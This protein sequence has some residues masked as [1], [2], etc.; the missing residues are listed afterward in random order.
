[1][2]RIKF[3][4]LKP[5]DIILTASK[6]K[7]GKS[8]RIF[9]QGIVSHAMIYVQ[10]G[11]IIDSTSDGVQ[12]RNLQRE[13][14]KDDELFFAFRMKEKLPAHKIAEVVDFARSEIGTR[15]SKAEAARSLLGG[16]KPRNKRE[17]C[18]RLVARA[19]QSVGVQLVPDHDYCSPEDLRNSSLLIELPV[20]LE[21]ITV[22]E[23]AW[24]DTQINLIKM[25]QDAHNELL[26]VARRFDASIENF[27][28]LDRLVQE[29]PECDATIAKAYRES[30]YLD[31]WKH[32]HETHPWRYDFDAMLSMQNASN[33]EELR[34]YCIQ[35]ISEAYS[36][37]IRFSVNL[38]YYQHAQ[39]IAHRETLDQLILLYKTLVQNDEN[40]REVARKWLLKY[41]PDDVKQHMER[42][43]PHSEL[44]FSIVDRVEPQLGV[45]ARVAIEAEQSKEICSSCGDE[46]ATD[47]RVANSAEAM[48]G[49]PSLRLCDDCHSI[50]LSFGEKLELLDY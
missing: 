49:V 6:S 31:L 8:V 15:Y 38:I 27:Q 12:A 43:K 37:G 18:S 36:G 22:D 5:G 16:P 19:Y 50:R 13:L 45:I 46:P 3:E 44:W 48:P 1:M 17:F 33:L 42:V 25:T 24:M 9:T 21:P 29:C 28:D 32:E 2:K 4:T 10:H 34:D 30:G 23:I 14:F 35:T 41:Y 40:R 20:V 7:V 26:S 39:T 11:S 47:Y